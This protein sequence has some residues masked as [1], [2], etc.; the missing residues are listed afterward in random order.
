MIKAKD[1]LRSLSPWMVTCLGL[2]LSVLEAGCSGMSGLRSV[3]TERPSFLGFWDRSG[4]LADSRKRLLRAGH[5]GRPASP[6]DCQ[7]KRRAA[8]KPSR[9]SRPR[10]TSRSPRRSSRARACQTL[11]R[12]PDERDDTIRFRWDARS[13]CRALAASDCRSRRRWRRQRARPHGRA[14]EDRPRSRQ[15][16]PT[17][18]RPPIGDDITSRSSASL[19]ARAVPSRQTLTDGKPSCARREAEARH[20]LKTYQVKISRLE[21]VNGQLQPEEDILLSIRRDPKAVRLEWSS[22]PS[23]GR[24]VIYSSTLD[25]R[26]IF[27]HMPQR[28]DSTSGHEDPRR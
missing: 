22:G 28:G 17:S 2:G 9:T 19:S 3:G 8:P 26:M 20:A 25:P 15:T 24:E 27:V 1:C 5:A 21:R 7:A 13:R 12:D 10:R 14:R 16:S 18:R 4:G 11:T 23:K 6:N